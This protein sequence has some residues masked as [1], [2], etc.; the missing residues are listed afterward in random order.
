MKIYIILKNN[1]EEYEDYDDWIE[2]IYENKESAENRFIEL[3]KTNK[4][5]EDRIIR[6]A[7]YNEDIGAYRLEEHKLIKERE[8]K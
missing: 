6:K 3:V 1:E 8:E 4:Y 2:E 7:R 5:K